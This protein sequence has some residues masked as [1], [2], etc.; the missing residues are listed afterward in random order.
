MATTHKVVK[1]YK[2]SRDIRVEQVPVPTIQ[3]PDDAIIRVTLSGLC[4]SDLHAYR[5]REAFAS[6]FVCG[7]EFVGEVVSLGG[8][9]KTVNPDAKTE[10]RDNLYEMLKVGDKVV[11]PFSTSCAE[12]QMCRKGFTCRC[13]KQKLLGTPVTPGA[14]AQFI[15]VPTAG[16]TLNVVDKTSTLPDSALLVLADILPT[17]YFAALQLLNHPNLQPSLSGK[18]LP[19]FAKPVEPKISLYS[20]T[21]PVPADDGL[22]IAVIGLG[23][24]GVCA[25]IALLDLVYPSGQSVEGGIAPRIYAID[26]QSSRQDYAKNIVARYWDTNLVT[27]VGTDEAPKDTFNGVLEVVGNDSA[28]TLGY[29]LIQPFGVIV[30]VGVHSDSVPFTLRGGQMYNK[31]VALHFGRCP[32]RPLLPL[33][34]DLLERRRDIFAEIGTET[35]LVQKVVSIDEAK[36]AYEKFDSGVWGKVLF[37]PWT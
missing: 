25:L 36:V 21:P 15:R 11:S 2:P 37:D 20:E 1:L 33:A 28:L 14:Q 19:L 26:P 13:V 8:S 4:G 17:G 18:P 32:V 23:P 5:G 6:E 24:V 3:E 22:N 10:G 31:N 30:S 16:G 12:C 34:K 7:H 9:F 29:N 35:A 27:F